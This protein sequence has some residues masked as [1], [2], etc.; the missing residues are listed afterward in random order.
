[1]FLV[2]LHARAQLHVHARRCVEAE[3]LGHLDEVEF[4]D[5]ED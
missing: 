1:L 5:V 3:T 2:H 4:V